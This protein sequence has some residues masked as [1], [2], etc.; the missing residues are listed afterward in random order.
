MTS[1][2][3]ENTRALA[4]DMQHEDVSDSKV[5]PEESGDAQRIPLRSQALGDTL[6]RMGCLKAQDIPAVLRHSARTGKK[7]GMSALALGLVS[8]RD[9]TA[10]LSI[11]QGLFHGDGDRIRVPPALVTL[12]RPHTEEAEQF[13][14]L[15]TRLLTRSD[16]TALRMLCVSGA[17][18][19]TTSSFVAVNLAVSIA[20][21]GRKV[22]LVDTNLRLSHLNQLLGLRQHV[23]LTEV[24]NGDSDIA[25][26]FAPALVRN[27]TYLPAG[28]P[29]FNPQE[30]LCSEAFARIILQ[31]TERFDSVILNTGDGLDTADAQLVWAL[32]K[33]VLLVARRDKTRMPDIRDA[34]S[35][36]AESRAHLVGTV[37]TK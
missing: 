37:M 10:A 34:T 13:R 15:R 23:G 35:L 19:Q 18:A 21:L 3:S 20:Q 7:F 9:I 30:V 6:V 4:S 26:A 24:V 25:E 5:A 8:K 11:Q 22:L 29:A 1:A 17:G 27:F 36:V 12:H 2:T 33:S 31:Q 32:A 16:G 28:R 14:R